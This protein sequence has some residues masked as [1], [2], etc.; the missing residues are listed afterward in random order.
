MS[1]GR[2][3][4]GFS[5]PL[6]CCGR[7]HHVQTSALFEEFSCPSCEE[8]RSE[9]ALSLVPAF[10]CFPAE[11]IFS[12]R[13]TADGGGALF[14]LYLRMTGRHSEEQAT[15]PSDWEFQMQDCDPL[16][17]TD[18]AL[19]TGTSEDFSGVVGGAML[20]QQRVAFSSMPGQ[21]FRILLGLLAPRSQKPQLLR[22]SGLVAF[23][24]KSFFFS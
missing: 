18:T 10:S 12:E 23:A 16:V 24:S 20:F 8:F 15:L 13:G 3:M 7:V 1:D 17:S 2:E 22:Q 4:P 21:R 19:V 9:R 5:V 14:E 11:N 6:P